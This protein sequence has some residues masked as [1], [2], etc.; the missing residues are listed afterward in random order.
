MTTNSMQSTGLSTDAGR[1]APATADTGLL[2]L[3][4]ALAATMLQAG[5]IKAL[6]FSTTAGFMESSGWS[7]PTF[8]ALMVTAAETLG[9]LGLL[10]G[11]LTPLAACAVIGAMVDAWAVNVSAGAFWSQPFNVPFLVAFGAAALLFTGAGRWSVDHRLFGRSTV[12]RAIAVGLLVA[13]V[14]AAILTWILLNGVNPIH[15][16]APEG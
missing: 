15:F 14:A 8:A 13:G 6:D 3:R 16:R 11:F 7:L 9:G 10:F 5:L 4:I 12:P 1:S 2:I